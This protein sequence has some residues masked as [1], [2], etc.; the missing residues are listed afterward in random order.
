[1]QRRT[2]FQL[3][4]AAALLRKSLTGQ[5]AGARAASG[6]GGGHPEDFPGLD[7]RSTVAIEHGDGPPA[8][9]LQRAEGHRQGSAGEDEGQEV[10]R[11]QAELRQHREPAGGQPRRLPCAAFWIT[12]P[13]SFKGPVVIAESSAGNTQ[14]GYEN[15]KYSALPRST[16]SS[17]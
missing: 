10:R 2:L 17:S 5:T 16:A 7:R 8:E 12:W 11:H 6:R 15:F 13:S 9:R 14:Q 4:G 3:A 1:M